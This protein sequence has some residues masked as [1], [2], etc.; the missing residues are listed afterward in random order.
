MKLAD[1]YGPAHL[2]DL[3]QKPEWYIHGQGAE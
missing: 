2:A 1:T 3:T